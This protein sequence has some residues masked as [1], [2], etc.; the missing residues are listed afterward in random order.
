VKLD[1]FSSLNILNCGMQIL[2]GAI[3]VVCIANR[4]R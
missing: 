1:K 4:L 3:L 2:Y